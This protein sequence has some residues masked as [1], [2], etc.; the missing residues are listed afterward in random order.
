LFLH[1]YL[2]GADGNFSGY[3][4]E[5]D[6]GS[7]G[8]YESGDYELLHFD[9]KLEKGEISIALNRT[10]KGWSGM[11]ESRLLEVVVYG[12]EKKLKEIQYDGKK[13]SELKKE[14]QKGIKP[15]FWQDENGQ[16]H[17]RVVWPGHETV[18][19]AK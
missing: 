17:I 14:D 9:G 15:G 7:F 16:W 4:F 6:G 13:L 19:L 1:T 3:M 8:T 12:L 2:P 18:I 5:D 10:G 11:P